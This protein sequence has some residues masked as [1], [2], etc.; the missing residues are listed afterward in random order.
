MLIRELLSYCPLSVKGDGAEYVA[1]KL[2][3]IG[4]GV[5]TSPVRLRYVTGSDVRQVWT[6]EDST[7]LHRG[8]VDCAH[9][10]ACDAYFGRGRV[11]RD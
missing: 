6:K 4:Y 1:R 11:V 8:R 9:D 5:R 3:A 7:I 2:N 10:A